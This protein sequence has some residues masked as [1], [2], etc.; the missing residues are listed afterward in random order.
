[1]TNDNLDLVIKLSD[2]LSAQQKT[3]VAPNIYS[4]AQA[5]VNQD[6]AWARA[7]YL[8]DTPIGFMMV[9]LKPLESK[10]G[11]KAYFLWRFMIE[12][13]HQKKGYGQKALD[14]LI[15]KCHKDGID[16]LYSS[17]DIKEAM[18]YQF[19]M[20][21]GFIDTGI[22]DVDEQVLKLEVKAI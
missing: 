13:Q 1:M 15:K 18:P 12:S 8:G 17:C 14:L 5:Y 22:L 11:E 2:T 9:D 10:K 20:S 16:F 6:I 7:I 4:I 3:C 21:Y 19:Y